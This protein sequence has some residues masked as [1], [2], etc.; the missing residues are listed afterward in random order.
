MDQAE[1]VEVFVAGV[2]AVGFDAFDGVVGVRGAVGKAALAERFVAEFLDGDA[3]FADH[4][5]GAQCVVVQVLDGDGDAEAVFLDDGDGA[6]ASIDV[7]PMLGGQIG[8]GILF[9]EQ[10]AGTVG[11]DVDGPFLG[12]IVNSATQIEGYGMSQFLLPG[13]DPV[14][15]SQDE[16]AFF[17]QLGARM[18]QLRKAQG[19]TQVQMAEWLGVSQQTV[20][21]YEVGR[22]RIQVSALPTVAKLLG[23]ALEELIGEPPQPGKRGPAP[24]LQRQMERIQELPKPKQRFVMEML[25]TVL[26]QASR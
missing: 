13:I 16:K 14:A 8:G 17:A 24:K 5:D 18:A 25:D 21:A 26:A 1:V 9:V 15:L 4:V 11:V 3:V 10:A 20:N 12:G 7:E 6:P 19:I 22:R 23:V 2:A